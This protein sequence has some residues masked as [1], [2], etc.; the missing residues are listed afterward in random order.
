MFRVSVARCGH[1]ALVVFGSGG[2]NGVGREGY[3]WRSRPIVMDSRCT[4]ALP[5]VATSSVVGRLDDDAGGRV[6]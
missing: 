2:R 5:T 6:T 1:M 4:Q 3:V